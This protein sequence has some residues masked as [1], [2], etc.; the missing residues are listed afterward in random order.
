MY[1]VH[2]TRSLASHPL[3]L[4]TF[5]EHTFAGQDLLWLPHHATLRNAGRKRKTEH[6]AGRIAAVHAL[7]ERGYSAPPPVGDQGQPVW[8]PGLYGSISHSGNRAVAVVSRAPIGVDIETLPAPAVCDDIA[9]GIVDAHESA[10]LRASPLPWPLALTLAFS[11]KESAYK[12]FSFRAVPFP[13][14]HSAKLVAVGRHRVRLRFTAEFSVDLAGKCIEIDWMSEQN[15]L[16][17]L[18][19]APS[20]EA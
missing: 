12:C 8:P 18:A 19:T 13:G 11:A 20:S 1:S 17:T 3:H 6:L 9:P 10:L 5:D 2:A 14:F 7:R 4:I 16:I 15:Q